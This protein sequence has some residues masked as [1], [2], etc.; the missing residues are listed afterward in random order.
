MSNFSNPA[1]FSNDIKTFQVGALRVQI[2]GSAAEM[3]EHSAQI[4]GEYLQEILKQKNSANIILATGQSQIEFLQNLVAKA[5]LDWSKITLFH[6]DEYLGIDANNPASF[7]YYL[8]EKV[9]K[10]VKPK[11]FY[12]LEGDTNQPLQECERY[13]QLLQAYPSDLVCLGIGDNGH[14]AFNEPAVADFEDPKTVKLVKLESTTRLQLLNGGDFPEIEL[15]PQ[16]AF[17]LT[18]PVI[19]AAKKILCFAPKKRKAKIIQTILESSITPKIPASILRNQ[20]QA[21]LF[22]DN[23]SASILNI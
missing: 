7:R 23:D 18:I 8:R 22:L 21:T 15:V 12:Y 6:L 5:E 4:A 9:E 19:C 3:A 2:Y 1:P 16:Y 17:T 20:P 13:S 14:I 11:E 10:L